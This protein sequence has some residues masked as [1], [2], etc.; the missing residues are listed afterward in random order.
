V[1]LAKVIL[2]LSMGFAMFPP[3]NAA[4]FDLGTISGTTYLA[5]I[6][7]PGSFK[8]SF[9]FDLTSPSDLSAHFNPIFGVSGFKWSL[10]EFIGGEY[11]SLG[12]HPSFSDLGSG[13][14]EFVF[15][16]TAAIPGVYFGDFHVSAVPEIDTWLML[17]LGAGLL[18]YQLRRR[19]RALRRPLAA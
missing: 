17:L 10:D 19:Q 6:D 1:N 11:V 14:Y 12:R 4:V 3:V 16:G 9:G 15:T 2:A 7:G 13:L 18:A 8:D 5:G